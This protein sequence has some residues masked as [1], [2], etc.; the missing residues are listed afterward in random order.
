[1]HVHVRCINDAATCNT[2]ITAPCHPTFRAKSIKN[3]VAVN[4]E[5]TA[6]EW[7]RR[8]EKEHEIAQKL[9]LVV[10]QQEAELVRWRAG[11]SVP[12]AERSRL[13]LK[14]VVMSAASAVE[15][16]PPVGMQSSS[17]ATLQ[18]ATPSLQ[19]TTPTVTPSATPTPAQT[20]VFEEERSRLCQQLD[21]KVQMCVYTYVYSVYMYMCIKKVTSTYILY[22]VH[23]CKLYMYIVH[24]TCCLFPTFL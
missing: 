9:R 21:E 1:M 5:L 10:Q 2:V 20:R 8:F 7:R 19:M 6:E 14:N 11:E 13:K 3:K 12:E 23:N 16:A 24:D 22:I 18:L 4:V 15:D 17:P